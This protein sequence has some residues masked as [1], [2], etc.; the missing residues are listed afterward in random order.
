MIKKNQFLLSQNFTEIIAVTMIG[1]LLLFYSI[2]LSWP[3]GNPYDLVNVTIS[4]GSS[5][6]QVSQTLYVEKVIRNKKTFLLAVK[7]MGY[8]KDFPAGKFKLIKAGSNFEIIKQLVSGNQISKRVTILEGWTIDAIAEALEDKVGLKSELFKAAT[9]DD[10][11]LYKW[12]IKNESFEGYLYPETYHFAGNENAETIINRMVSEYRSKITD[13]MRDRML[14]IKMNENEV[15]TLASIIEGEAIFDDERPV[16][17]G[18]YHNRLKIGMRLQADPT[19]QYIINDS[20]RRL[21]NKDLRIK[22]PYNT[23]LNKGLPPGPI[24]NPSI[25]SIKA[26]LYPTDSNFFYFVAKGNGYHTFTENKKEHNKA[27][28]KF[29]KVRREAK[30]KK[31]LK[32]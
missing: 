11:L 30:R 17:A 8:E 25:E 14:E 3:Q 5:L 19:I 16:I 27:K 10:F 22:S 2:I 28:R 20:P 1:S 9:K 29:Q 6:N 4:K 21:L 15:L 18:V 32:R 13:S 12:D 23:Y 31:K 26:A 7:A 24:N